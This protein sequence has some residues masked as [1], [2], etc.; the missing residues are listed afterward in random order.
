MDDAFFFALPPHQLFFSLPTQ[1]NQQQP[2]KIQQSKEAKALAAANSSKGKKKVRFDLEQQ[3]SPA[4]TAGGGSSDR[5]FL[6]SVAAFCLSALQGEDAFHGATQLASCRPMGSL[7]RES[8]PK[9]LV[10]GRSER[11][12]RR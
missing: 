6:R 7:Y 2:P 12:R 8:A 1:T 3:N 4:T 11:R 10:G 9:R 5:V